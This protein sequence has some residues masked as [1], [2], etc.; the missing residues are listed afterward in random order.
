M[1]VDMRYYEACLRDPSYFVEDAIKQ[2]FQDNPE[3]ALDIVR[4]MDRDDEPFDF[5]ILEDRLRHM[6]A[7]N[8]FNIGMMSADKCSLVDDYFRFDAYGH[9]ESLSEE[10]LHDWCMDVIGWSIQDVIDG[11]Y[12]IPAELDGI[13][14]MWLR[15]PEDVSYNRKPVSKA[16][17]KK[18][19]PKK[20]TSKKV[21]STKKAV[22]KNVKAKATAKA[23]PKKPTPAR[24]KASGRVV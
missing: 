2:Y 7:V 13:I 20:T 4:Q 24:K 1:T 5:D 16:P 9:V 12:D 15:G 19:S 8:A 18:C 10:E 21:C 11:R 3:V 23:P 14:G 22:S 6:G 17:A